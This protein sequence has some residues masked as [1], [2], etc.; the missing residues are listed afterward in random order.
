[1]AG[2]A[3]IMCKY[4]AGDKVLQLKEFDPF[5]FHDFYKVTE[6][7]DEPN[8]LIKRAEDLIDDYDKIIIHDYSEFRFHFPKDKVILLFHGTKLREMPDADKEPLKEYPCYVTTVDLLD[9]I[10][11]TLLPAPIDLEH[12]TDSHIEPA[13]LDDWF[14][15]NRSYQR[16]FIESDMRTLFP[17]LEYYERNAAN[18]IQYSDMPHFLE[19]HENYV[20]MKYT[21]DKPIPKRVNFLSC[22][23]L[24]AMAVGC[25]VWTANGQADRKE[26]L[27][28]DAK[29]VTERF[30]DDY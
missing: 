28:H 4:G 26:L 15:I 7:F 2:V 25:K 27:I 10:P 9:I 20:D 6:L 3:E 1:M 22:T 14:T 19:Q 17:R 16:D 12:F 8:A 23:A 29:R 21:Y 5:G 24:Q 11:S 18:I 30:L 13:D